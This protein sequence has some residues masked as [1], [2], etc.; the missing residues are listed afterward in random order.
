MSRDLQDERAF[1]RG[2]KCRERVRR[3]LC[4]TN[5]SYPAW[6]YAD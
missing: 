2:Q 5:S 6:Q 1:R 4:R 3:E